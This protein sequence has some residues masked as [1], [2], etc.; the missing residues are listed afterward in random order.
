MKVRI[1][2][3]AGR[4]ATSSKELGALADDLVE[5]GFDSIWLSEVLTGEGLDPLVGLAF[6]A[7]HN[8]TLKLGTTM[9][10]PGRNPV[11]LAKSLAS[12]D[13][14][15]DG[16]LLITFVPGLVDPP[17]RDA[18]G[19][20]PSRRAAAIEDGLPLVRELLSGEPVS[21]DG[22][23]G[24]FSEVLVTPET[25]QQPL[26]F[27]L[28]GMVPSSLVRC[29]QL[30]DGWLPSLCTPEEALAG[31]KVIDEAAADAGREISPEH[32]GVS[33]GYAPDGLD[34][35]ALANLRRR[36][37]GR[38]TAGLVP[39]G[40]AA[41]RATIEGFVDVGFSKFVV[42]PITLARGW[43]GELEGI[44]EAVGDLQS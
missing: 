38:D 37:R 16:R 7:A 36:R 5:L 14:L 11:R 35:R 13:V 30:G 34:D 17:E 18:I 28:G 29:G 1:G 44:A 25:V 21:Y 26:E 23:L 6:V 40:Q 8:S 3:G 10:L 42:R 32:F 20:E 41:L 39:V 33:V 24:S 22:P 2:I 12:L 19:L 9:L 4:A 27:W 43:R 15:S 31:K